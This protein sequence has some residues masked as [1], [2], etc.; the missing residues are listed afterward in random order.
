MYADAT[1]NG[2]I[3]TVENVTISKD[4]TIILT[5]ATQSVSSAGNYDFSTTAHNASKL[6][7]NT[8]TARFT[9]T[10][11][12][13][14]VITAATWTVDD[15]ANTITGVPAA[16]TLAAFKTDITAPSSGSFEVYE[17]DGTTVA[18]DLA[19][20]YKL[21]STAENGATKTYTIT[22]DA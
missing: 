20:T 1:Y 18:S 13:V 5:F 9:S 19:S 2:N 8:A 21:I 17:A 11:N 3:L 12:D 15:G 7:G 14:V 6:I 4:Q 10:L 22:L 16:T